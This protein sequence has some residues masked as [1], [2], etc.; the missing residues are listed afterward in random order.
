[1]LKEARAHATRFENLAVH[2]LGSLKLAMIRTYLR[3]GVSN[4]A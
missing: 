4:R 1:L 2:F 3:A